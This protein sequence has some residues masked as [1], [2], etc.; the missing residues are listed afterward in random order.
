MT[1]SESSTRDNTQFSA[2]GGD[3][4]STDDKILLPIYDAVS[5][6]NIWDRHLTQ[7]MRV[8]LYTE[9]LL[10]LL[11]RDEYRSEEREHYDSL[12][13][14]LKLLD[15]I[16]TNTGLEHEAISDT[17]LYD[18]L[19]LIE[20]MDQAANITPDVERQ[21]QM[22]KTVLSD[23]RN[24]EE[25]QR[26]FKR[27]Y[28]DLASGHAVQ[29]ELAVRLIEERHTARG[30]IVLHL[31]SEATN[32]LLNALAYDI[33]DAQAA[34]EAVVQS[35]L[36]R[37]HL[38]DAINS[39]Q[40][41]R[42]QSNILRGKIEQLLS[43]TRRDLSHV[44]WKQEVP[45][46]LKESLIHLEDRCDVEHNI[47]KSA[48]EK[49]DALVPESEE[50]YHLTKLISIIDD[51][52][53]CHMELQQQ[54]MEAPRV[55]LDEQ[56]RQVFALRRRVDL[57]NIRTDIL[58]PLFSMQR[59]VA[60]QALPTI[61][62]NC[63]GVRAPNAFSL[64]QH[65]LRLLHPR[66]GP[67]P[68]TVPIVERESI[69]TSYNQSRYALDVYKRAKSYLVLPQ[70]PVRLSFLLQQAVDAGE[71]ESTLEVILFSILRHFDLYDVDA[72]AFLVV[73]SDDEQFLID[74]FS[75]DNVL[76]RNFEK[77]KNNG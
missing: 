21:M 62:A 31:S 32:L 77:E 58:S 13:L 4:L 67:R 53:Q 12:T 18:I 50:A 66:R 73:K 14:A 75:G 33:E 22:A 44:D 16:V 24:D 23:L 25:G 1:T 54:L 5:I 72:P 76:L 64:S 65:L 41:A 43:S 51:C 29:R 57:P 17:V 36:R 34:A 74:H 68:Q 60:E 38:Q 45:R 10:R 52:R 49:Q 47:I 71:P 3:L 56:E 26:P 48:R 20:A 59:V 69:V 35:Q 39:A 19:P 40:V 55:F 2:E 30:D 70:G 15:H 46:I 8:L 7:Q 28:T 6:R 27:V 9:P 61:F 37:G 63:L 11:R 42:W